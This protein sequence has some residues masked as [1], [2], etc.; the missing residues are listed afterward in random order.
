MIAKAKF[1][2]TAAGL[3]GK[4]IS[5]NNDIDG[6]WGLGVLYLEARASA[7]RI[8]LDL[9]EGTAQPP[10]PVCTGAAH[11]WALYLRAA[12]ARH[13]LAA[14]ALAAATLS[15]E[16]GLPVP[17]RPPYIPH[18]DPFGCVV[19]LR[20]ADGREFIRRE[21]GYCLPWDQF[22]GSRSTRWPA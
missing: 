8:V 7:N 9:R 20:A 19:H 13:G 18:G 16:F 3:L 5:R 14:D 1:N 21:I 11:T 2:H 6:Y 12:L 22:H 17:K 10:S 4:F 15:I